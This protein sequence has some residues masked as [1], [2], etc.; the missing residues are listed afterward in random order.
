MLAANVK[1]FQ[2]SK[3]IQPSKK[4]VVIKKWPTG[5]LILICILEVI[6][7]PINTKYYMDY[8]LA[9]LFKANSNGNI[10]LSQSCVVKWTTCGLQAY[11]QRRLLQWNYTKTG[12]SRVLSD[13]E[14]TDIKWLKSLAIPTTMD[15]QFIISTFPIQKSL[16]TREQATK[17]N[18]E[19]WQRQHQMDEDIY[20]LR[21]VQELCPFD[22]QKFFISFKV[23]YIQTSTLIED[24]GGT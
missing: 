19:N 11:L 16:G 21:Y 12:R 18:N 6:T 2:Y 20:A 13:K 8:L 17:R 3:F 24:A 4:I 9:V 22:R 23:S 1:L 14:K 15:I 5:K 10:S 7:F